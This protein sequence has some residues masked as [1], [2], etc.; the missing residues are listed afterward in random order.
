MIQ[1][2]SISK[3]YHQR[4]RIT[5]ALDNVSVNVPPGE[6]LLIEGDSGTGKTTLLNII[7]CLTRPSSGVLTILG[8]TVGDLPEHFLAGFRREHIGFMFQQFNLLP[9]FTVLQNVLMPLV[10]SG[11]GHLGSERHACEL[12]ERL[13]MNHRLSYGV[14]ELSAGEQQRVAL[15]R[16]LVRDPDIILADEPNSSLD[17]AHTCTVIEML[18]ELRERGKTIVIS[19]H[20]PM[21]KGSQLVDQR[22][23]L[24]ARSDE[25]IGSL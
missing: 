10:P 1:L 8:E 25:R 20:D 4:R 24:A 22:L 6:C 12:L 21:V 23:L 13:N 9:G 17:E 7:G 18:Y 2:R 11:I 3:V 14:D 5:R 19:S 15:A 16:A